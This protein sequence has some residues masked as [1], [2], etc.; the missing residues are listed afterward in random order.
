M[1]HAQRTAGCDADIRRRA[2][3]V[4]RDDARPADLAAGLD[5]GNQCADRA[6]QEQRHGSVAR[7]GHRCN[8]AAGGHQVELGVDACGGDSLGKTFEIPCCLRADVGVQCRRRETLVLAIQRRHFVTD[9]KIRVRAFLG[10]DCLDALFMHRIQKRH[11]AADRDRLDAVVAQASRRGAHLVL[12]ERRLDTTVR[13]GDAFGDR[14]AV[15]APHQRLGL[16]RDRL[17]MREVER[18]VLAPDVQ[19]V[20][21]TARRQHADAGPVFLQQ[22]VSGD[23][24]AV[25]EEVEIARRHAGAFQQTGQPFNAGPRG[26][27][28]CRGELEDGALPVRVVPEDEVGEGAADI[29]GRAPHGLPRLIWYTRLIDFELNCYF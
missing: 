4:E 29:D 20:A 11:Q 7:A 18:P 16:A 10:D 21:K 24:R 22:D 2:A 13:C 28:R 9:G 3:D 17:R 1:L 8:A 26:I 25:D 23:G 14:Q 27:V 12:V 5:A 6:R 15:T 19:H